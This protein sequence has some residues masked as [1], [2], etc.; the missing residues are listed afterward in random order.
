MHC[1]KTINVKKQYGFERLFLLSALIGVGVFIS[2]YIALNIIYTAPLSDQHFLLF[3]LAT[4]GIYPLHKMCHFIPLFGCRKCIR[5]MLT[6]QMGLMP[7][8]TLKI[9]EPVA[10]KR[11][12]LT[13]V[14]PFF[15]INAAIIAASISMPAFSHYFAMLLAYHCGLCVPDLIYMR[16]LARSP[17]HALIEET[18]T[19]F[20][21]LVPQPMA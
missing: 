6:K 1:W 15:L 17:K 4:L 7:I 19:G 3:I 14:T 5:L 8:I 9:A 18:D 11:F 13:L 16:N 2:F 10:K 12:I 20:E 21:I